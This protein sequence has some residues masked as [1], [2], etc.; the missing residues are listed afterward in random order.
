MKRIF[1]LMMLCV[2]VLSLFAETAYEK[3]VH[4]IKM[5]Y[6]L[7]FKNGFYSAA[8]MEDYYLISMLGGVDGALAM[9]QL[10]YGLK[11]PD[12]M[13][14]MTD[15]MNK[16]LEQAK[17]LMS[18]E[19]RINEWKKSDYGKM[20]SWIEKSY[21]AKFTKDEFETK[22]QYYTRIMGDAKVLF[23]EKCTSLQ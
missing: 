3:K 12:Q 20:V 4:E 23:N 22:N 15:R 13:K 2:S 6:F 16:E 9:A 10:D 17:S 5:E 19:D 14:M 21:S 11:Y 1:I 7:F 8:T 18:E